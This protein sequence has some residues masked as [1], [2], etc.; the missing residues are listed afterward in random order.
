MLTKQDGDSDPR[1][2]RRGELHDYGSIA[3][4]VD[5]KSSQSEDTVRAHDIIEHNFKGLIDTSKPYAREST[6]LCQAMSMVALFNYTSSMEH[7][8]RAT[9]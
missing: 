5:F 9:P 6:Q 4:M 8:P 2:V 3:N 1:G 7:I